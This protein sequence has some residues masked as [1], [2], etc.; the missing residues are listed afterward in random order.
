MKDFEQ[1]PPRRA[2]NRAE[3]A[4]YVG[5]SPNTFDKLIGERKMPAPKR[6]YARKV[7]DLRE[8]DSAFEMLDSTDSE[9]NPLDAIESI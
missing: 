5:I 2:L 4:R 6:I 3:A 8:L 7:W 9:T 1:S